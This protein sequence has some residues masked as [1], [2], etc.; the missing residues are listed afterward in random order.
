MLGYSLERED[1]L[2]GMDAKTGQPVQPAWSTQNAGL[3]YSDLAGHW[4]REEIETLAKYDVGYSGG[5]FRPDNALTQLDLIALLASTEG[6]LYDSDAEDGADQ[7]YEY[8]YGLGLLSRAE[9]N[10]SAVLTRTQT[11][12]LILDAVGYGSVAR[13]EGIF[14]T[15]FA[16]DGSIPADCYGYVALGQGLRMV[17]GDSGGKFL[18]NAQ[19]TRA[20][21]AVMLYNLMAR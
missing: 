21:A 13:L 5:A 14:R 8:A 6:Y 19:A 15:K 1:Y 3:A 2:S 10:D 16:D 17:T 4:A 7:L 20:Q 18:P 9:R 12:R 11:V